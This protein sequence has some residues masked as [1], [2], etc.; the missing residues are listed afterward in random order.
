MLRS[1]QIAQKE[2]ANSIAVTYD[3]VIAKTATQIQK[4][5][6]LVSGNI[7]IVLVYLYRNS[8]LQ[9]PR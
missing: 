7:F 3:L 8:I 6:S 2:K 5:K 4:E 1:L 9:G